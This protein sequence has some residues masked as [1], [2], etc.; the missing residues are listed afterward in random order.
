MPDRISI[1]TLGDH[2][3]G[4]YTLTAHCFCGR[5]SPVD[6]AALAA[7]LGREWVPIRRQLLKRLRC[8]TC[9]GH[10]QCVV[11]GPPRHGA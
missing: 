5:S 1:V 4:G 8:T 9:G 7:R 11:I 3:D 2:L 6:L 10:P